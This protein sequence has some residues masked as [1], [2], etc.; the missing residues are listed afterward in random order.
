MFADYFVE[1]PRSPATVFRRRFRIRRPLFLRIVNALSSRYEYFQLHTNATGKIG[2]SPLQK[3]TVV[4]RQL[5]YEGT[6][7][8][9]D[10]YLNVIEMTGRE[11]LKNFCRGVRET[12]RDTY[13]WKLTSAD[14]Q[15]L[16]DLHGRTHNFPGILGSIDCMHWEWMNCPT[17]WRGQ[18]TTKFKGTHP[19]VILEAI[20]D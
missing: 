14:C 20:A 8:M 1:V 12:F 19:T 17:T 4:V 3:C 6:T 7:D 10:E 5:T 16:L 18:F 15:F 13:L 11:C 2:L 9:F